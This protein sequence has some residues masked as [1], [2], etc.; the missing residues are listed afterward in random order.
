MSIIY[1]EIAHLRIFFAL[2]IVKCVLTEYHRATP[3]VLRHIDM[4][5]STQK[6][7]SENDRT[8]LDR[9]RNEGSV[10]VAGLCEWMKVTATAIR[11]RLSRLEA[12]GL[13]ERV[14]ARQDR[15]RPLHLYQ[16]TPKGLEAMGENLADLAE[17]L[18]LEIIKIEDPEIRKSVI[19][20][21]LQRLVVK[22]R[23]QVSGD[24]I[25]ERLRSIA[26]L[27][28][29][30][31]IPFIVENE[32]NQAS[33]KIVGCPYPRLNDHGEEICQL[34]QQLIAE[35]LDAPVALNHCSCNSSGGRCCTFTAAAQRELNQLPT[36][37]VRVEE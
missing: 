1:G 10:S 3:T 23:E 16:L 27:F 8:V 13:I 30:R 18:W 32:Q 36:R 29:E 9:I 11:Q 26:S 35:L 21:V 15:G 12:A 5:N 28:R 2:I 19:D 6:K 14:R 22:Y 37:E 17:V 7:L 20:G 4:S 24:T 33:L 31:K 25:T 34:E